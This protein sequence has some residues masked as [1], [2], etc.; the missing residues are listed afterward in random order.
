MKSIKIVAIIAFMLMIGFTASLHAATVTSNTDGNWSAT[1]WPNTGRTGTI[2]TTTGSSTVTG[3]GTLFTTEISVGNIIKRTDNTVIGTVASIS[4]NTSLTLTGNAANNNTNVA[5]RSQGVGSGDAVTIDVDDAVV[6]DV[7]SAA[8]ASINFSTSG[9]SGAASLTISGSNSLT[10]SGAVTIE[11]QG[12]LGSSNTIA[13]G[14][15][16]LTCAL[17]TLNGTTGGSRTSIITIST[18]T[19]DVSGN[20]TSAG[21]D[22]R[23]T[24]S[25][26]GTVYAGG[27]FMSGTAGTFTRSTGTVNYDASGNQ[28]I[29]GWYDYYNL[30][31]SGSGTKTLDGAMTVYG[32][33]TIDDGTTFADGGNQVTSTGT[34]NLNSGIFKLGAT[35]ATTFPAFA[36]RNITAG[37]TVE[38]ASGAAQT[39]SVTPSYSNL[40]F[41]GA[42]TKTVSAGTLTIGGNWEIQCNTALNTNNPTVNLTGNLALLGGTTTSTSGTFNIGGDWNFNNAIFTHNSGTVVFNG[43]S[44]NLYGASG[45]TLTF[46]NLTIS[47]TSCLLGRNIVIA[48]NLNITSGKVFDLATYTA[49]RSG[50]GGTLTVAG[51]M[52]LGATTGGQTGS[53]FPTNFT[54]LTMTGGTVEYYTAAGGQTIYSTPTYNNLILSNTSGTQTAGGAI[55]TTTLNTTAG[56]TFNMSTFALVLTNVTNAGTIRT[57]NT[58]GTPIPT[59]KTWGGTVQYDAATGGQTVMSGNYNILNNNN[60][61]NTNTASGAITAT[62]LNTSSGGTLNMVTYTLGLTNVT[63]A[64]TIRTQNTSGTPLSTGLTWGGTVTY[65]AV[66]GTQTVVTGTYT[67]LT[68]GNT[69]G[70]QTA[71]GNIS[72][73]TLNNNTNVADILNMVTYTL[74]ATTVNN[75]GTI[76]TQ[77]TSGTPLPTGKTW[78]GTIEYNGA[79]QTIV[80]GTYNNMN[81]NQS[82][83]NAMLGGITTVN[84]TLTLSNGI[85]NTSSYTLVIGSSGSISGANDSKY[86]N[87][88]LQKYVAASKAPVTYEI[89]DVYYAPVTVTFSGVSDDGDLIAKTT[90]GDHPNIATSHINSS[91]SVNRYW[92]LTNSGITYS[93]YDATFTFNNPDDLDGGVDTDSFYIDK[94][95]AGTWVLPT[96]GTRTSTSTQATGMSSL[97]DFQIGQRNI[98]TITFNQNGVNNDFTGNILNVE[99]TNYQYEDFPVSFDWES[100]SSHNYQYY[101]TLTVSDNRYIWTSTSGLASTKS[102]SITVSDTGSVTASYQTQYWVTYAANVSVTLPAD[103]W[104]LSGNAVTGLFPTAESSGGTK[105][106]YQSDDRPGTI[107]A[108]TTI[109]GTYDTYYWVTYASAAPITLPTDEWILSGNA[110]TGV[111]PTAESSGGTKYVYQSDDRPGTI[112]APTTITATYQTQYWV[113]YAANV[114]VTLPASEW[115]ASGNGATGVFPTAESSGGTKYVYQSDDRPGT[116]T[117]PTTITG[118]YDTYYWVTYASAAPITLPTDEWILS[119]NAATGVFPTAESSGGTKYVYQSDDR[120]GTITAPTTITATYQTQYWV[121]YAANVSVTLPADEWVVSGNAATG[122]FPTAESSGGTKYVY[123]SDD[124]PGTITA[125]TTITATYQTQYWVQYAA[126]VSVTLPADEWVA[127]GDAATGVFPTA[128]STGST[129][130]IYQ[131][132]DRPGTITAPTTI[133]GTYDTY[134]WVT[135]AS[136]APITLPTDE[137]ILSGN[138]ATGVFPTAESTGSTKYV[139]QSDDRPGTITAPTTITGTYDTYYWVTYASAAPITL[140][141]DEWILSGNAATGVFPTAESTGSTKYVYQSD[142]RPGTITAPTTIT[143]TYDTYYWVT[144]ASAA[145]IT[146]P[147]DEWILSGNAATGVFPTAESLGG[148]RYVYQSDDRPGTITA[149]T[150]IT[151]TYQTQYWVTYAANVSV[152]LPADEWVASGDAATGVFPTAESSGGTKYIYQSDDRPGTITAPTTI[153]GTYDT[154]YW[155]TYASA[156]PIT[157]PTDEWILSSNAATGV[158]PTAESTGGTKYVYLSDDRPGTITAPTTITATYQIQ[159]YLTV[160][161]LHSSTTGAGW[162]NSGV[163]AYAGVNDSIVGTTGTRYVFASWTDAATGTHIISEGILMDGPK[164]ATAT[165]QTQYMLT[166]ISVHSSTIGTG[167]FDS[168]VITSAGVADSIVT[169]GGLRYVFASWTGDATGTHIIS[170]GILMN[171]PKTATATWTTQFQLTVIITGSGTVNKV[172][173]QTYHD[174]LTYVHLTA[175]P[176][177]GWSFVNWTGD[178]NSIHNP[179]SILMTTVKTVTA[180]FTIN[181][182]TLTVNVNPSGSGTVTKNP[183]QPSYAYGTLVYL[184]ANPDTGWH[185]MNWSDSLTGTHNPDTI[186][187]KSNKVVTAHFAINTYTLHIDTVGNGGVVTNPATGPYNHG[188]YVKLTATPDLGWHF[189]GWSDSLVSTS[190]YDSVYMNSNKV[191]KANFAINT[192][193]LHVDTVGNGGVS[194]NPG[195]GPYNYNTY[196]KLT[197]VPDLG[198]HFMRWTDSLVSTHSYDSIKM[199]SNKVVKAN[200]AIDTLTITS[201]VGLNGTIDPLGIT[202]VTYGG[203]QVYTITPN[204]GYHVDDVLIDGDSYGAMTN[205][206]FTDV[207]ED[208]TISATFAINIYTLNISIVG[209]GSVEKS[210]DQLEYEHGT[211]VQLNA[212][213]LEDWS[214]TDWSGGITSTDNPITITMNS[215]TNITATFTFIGVPGWVQKDSIIVPQ[216]AKMIKDGG[217]LVGVPGEIKQASVLY[218]FVGTKTNRVR[219]YTVGAGWSDSDSLIFGFKYKAST[220]EINYEKLN[221]KFP[222]KG[223]AMCYDGDNNIIYATRGNG[224]NE[225]FAYYIDTVYGPVGETLAGW[226]LKAYVPTPKGLKGGTSIRYFDG[227]VYL[228]AGGQ[229]KDPTVNNFW[230]YDPI[231]D[232]V[233]GTP[234]T[235][236]GKL[237]LG[238]NTKVWKDGASIIEVNGTFYAVKSNDKL[239]LFYAYDWGTSTWLDKEVMPIDDSSYHKYKKKLIVK[240]GACT[241]TDG[242]VIYANKGGGTEVFWKYTPNAIPPDTGVWERIDRL[243]IE[244][245]DKKHAPKTGAAMAYLDGKIYLLVGNKQVDFWRFTSGAENA[246]VTRLTSQV[247]QTVNSQSTIRNPGFNFDISPNPFNKLTTI[248]YTV[249]ISGKVSV[250]LYNASGR[251]IKTLVHDNL[252]AGTYAM[253][254]S[255]D[256]LAKG[257][258]FVKYESDT[259]KSEV[260]LIVQ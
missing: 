106:V 234:W 79:S 66:A 182:Y 40:T 260:K 31:T 240:D 132:D 244:K 28:T 165:W 84:G 161:S 112:T 78:G 110:A 236:L 3:S 38:Y 56:G 95:D 128:E 187:I 45:N 250:K 141:T 155:V 166:V 173:N 134:Y 89:G 114:S 21:T 225:F 129:K 42:G 253:N 181:Y 179:D 185:F 174:S 81:V 146:L 195:S 140:P 91:K 237:P 97:S 228:M 149:P 27:T 259:N 68:M 76:R 189:V 18:G 61:S 82:S 158:F 186:R 211:P 62:T 168:G 242:S 251:L 14:A 94:R 257:V 216:P 152:T 164:T 80:T 124:R 255:A 176:S 2:T 33:L 86:V 148:T 5:Y 29:N 247:I 96:T 7:A 83:G 137:W 231:Q 207:I 238:P 60:T 15:G 122:V 70:T 104:I 170:D 34:L 230:A 109:T 256:K 243:P 58:S 177:E 69:S 98:Y 156:A 51:T 145:P 226:K 1:A 232:T 131:S 200:F 151:A 90:A 201:S 47:S 197:A 210:P 219:K 44:Q 213:P 135:Y 159:Y 184:T 171:G 215:D 25:S 136:A 150:T 121:T 167:W 233:G 194:V 103:E 218:A 115:V 202:N 36:T 102:G 13:V 20:I 126:N 160:N 162:Y 120:P 9:Y 191:V 223:A 183:D 50:A 37:T 93:T 53:N 123:Q 77:N 192:Y 55:T 88:N 59:G 4:S 74:S 144:Y 19:V 108:P 157:L 118:T 190:A 204:E 17:I 72:T 220:F 203:N 48:G 26:S 22:S 65:D 133:T 73:T 163:T 107:T 71:G 35:A 199:N 245:V 6:V 125:P 127:S 252:N 138:A 154:Y 57:Q 119:G 130:Y 143:G 39:V 75:S 49:N 11:R 142:D 239:N 214:F 153:T 117:A 241:A 196:V 43:G 172:P 105:Y 193:T 92:T 169:N 24:F 246:Q 249:P 116:I 175:I 209:S 258:Y 10:V 254:L 101:D 147:T 205:Y 206:E 224:T 23:I 248:H 52:R 41:S 64:G 54:T 30:T 235:P 12:S 139:Y 46:N 217:A 63:N 16:T 180:N 178:L 87:G 100:G 221:K 212:I 113:T 222:G 85:V 99:G 8:C 198:W 188:T 208:H 229:K 227:K 67:T 32:S 111:F